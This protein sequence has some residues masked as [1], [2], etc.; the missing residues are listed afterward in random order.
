MG[1]LTGEALAPLALALAIF[2]LLVDLMHRR[3]RW[4][5]H[6]PPGPVPL[7]GLGNLLQVDI[8][9][10]PYSLSQ[11]RRRFGDVFSLQLAWTP[12]V[13]INGLEA[14]REALVLRSE[15]TADRPPSPV[16]EFVGFGPRSQGRPFNPN[17]LLNKAVCNIIASLLHGRRFEYDDPTFLKLLEVVETAMTDNSGTLREVLNVVPVLLRIPGLAKK[18]FSTQITFMDLLDGLIAEH[19]ITRDP[20]QPPRDLTDAFLDEVD[21][22]KGNPESSF[23]KE[24]LRMVMGDLFFAGMVTTSSTLLWALLLMLLHPDVQRRVQE[25]IDKVIGQ[26]RPPEMADQAHMPYTTAVIH[27]VQRFG[28]LVPLS[29]PH[30]TFR[31]TEVKGF[32]IPK[33]TM[34]ITNLSSVLKDETIWKKPFRFDPEHFLD[35]QGHFIKQE[36][37]M[38]FSAGRRVC[39]GEPLARMEL[40][41]FFTCLL[42]RFHFSV[43]PGQPRPSDHGTYNILVTPAPYQLWLGN[44][45][46]VDIR[47]MPYSVG[48]VPNFPYPSERGQ[49]KKAH[50][51]YSQPGTDKLHPSSLQ[52]RS[53]NSEATMGL[54]TG[55]ALAPL[56]LA[57]AIF[58]LL[59]DLMHRRSRWAAR[60]PPGP[61]PLP[62]LGNLLQVDIRNMPYSLSQL[63]RRFGDVFSLQ[64]AWTPVVVINGLEAVRE[65]LVLRSEDTADRPPSPVDEFVGFGP[66]SQGV[67]QARYGHAWR[68]QRRFSVSTMRN[69]G[70]GKKSLEQWVTEEAACL[71]SA[72][73]A[74]AGRPF[75]PNALLNKAVCNI[76]TSLLHGRRFEYDDP[77]FLKLLEMVETTMTDNS[78]T[79]REVL[80]MVPVLLRIPGL[81]K[82]VFSTQI[83]FMDLLDGLIAEHQETRDP[84]QP[85]RDLTDAFLDEVDKAKGNPESSF[86][87]ENLRTVMG[88]L[89][90]AG[91]VT[92]SSTLAWALLLMLL[93][94]D[95]Q[96]RVQEEIEKVIGQGRPP[97]MADQ[98]H[99]PYTTAVIHEVQRFG[100][101]VPLGVPHMTFRDTEV[102]GFLIPKGTM[103]ITNLSSVLKDETVWKKPF[104]FDPEHFLD[105]QGRFVKQEAFMPFS[106]GRR[107]CLGEPLARMELFLFFT[108]L[109]QRFHFSVPPGQPRPSDH[110]TYNLLMTPAPYQ[111]CATPR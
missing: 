80:N 10:M 41:L 12:V 27:E 36:A 46:Q 24:N 26:G 87:K 1:L 85:P 45:L 22:A 67:I 48:Q 109:L 49:E 74:Q 21:K 28:D 102:K 30:M 14:V 94:P 71:C 4:A 81:A 66:R 92:T 16:D 70:L 107:V 15:D 39:L 40:F 76:I 5:A 93:H 84:T 37:F 59:V 96:R 64:L 108:C 111:L 69:F 23:N 20:T 60:Y 65:A 44:L 110:G 61:V 31:D 3:S 35:A 99:M 62:G 7:P 11:L 73:A 53:L 54:L 6:Y 32:L 51:D 97:E 8:R 103:I 104:R 91:M 29:V 68:E 98:A 79:L 78:G 47:N 52:Q 50:C 83:T 13:V 19:Q 75:N 9:N 56:A 77:T 2:L 106:A 88:D 72:F 58:L 105:A 17:A 55:E 63:R 57:L 101:L 90:F 18:V 86:N 43:P 100:D 95:V 33:G 25:E 82:K 34:I 38:P 42:Q 89:F